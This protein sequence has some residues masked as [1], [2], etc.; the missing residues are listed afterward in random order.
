MI[1]HA[2]AGMALMLGASGE[3]ATGESRFARA[4][5][6]R[7]RVA[8]RE[9]EMRISASD[10]LVIEMKLDGKWGDAEIN[11]HRLHAF[12]EEASAEDC[13]TVLANF[14]A[15]ATAEPPETVAANLRLV[16]RQQDYLDQL[17]EMQPADAQP[18][19]RQIGDD[20]Y[21]LLAF[22]GP[23]GVLMAIPEHLAELSL[24]EQAAWRLASEQTRGMLPRLPRPIDIVRSH[25][26]F[27]DGDL[28]TSLLADP[29]AWRGIA[30]EVGP[31]LAVVAT[32]DLFVFVGAL[33]AGYGRMREFK[34]AVRE[35]C[36]T[37]QRC[38]SPN[39]YRFRDGRWVFA[40]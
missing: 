37:A 21:A 13:D 23:S 33:P 10:P 29:E 5:L 9:T 15:R 20:L 31:D 8:E 27:E 1:R 30:D 16:V 12:C 6:E 32:S 39:V 36:A 17:R 25:V 40:E 19:Y 26:T 18:I 38:I 2:I 34:R 14:V 22:A 35:D 28:L 3:A 7:L 24:D 4:M 11:L